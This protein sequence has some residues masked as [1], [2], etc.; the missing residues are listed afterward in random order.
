MTPQQFF[1]ILWVRRKLVLIVFLVT[2]VIGTI[3]TLLLPTQYTASVSVVVDVK[4]DPIA[5]S[6]L[7]AIASPSYMTTQTEII[8]SDRVAMRVIKL[9]RYEQSAQLVDM[10]RENTE[11]RVPFDYYFATLLEKSL[12]VKPSRGSNIIGISYTAQSPQSAAA[13]AN[14]FAQAYID[15]TID[16]RVDPARQYAAWFDE[17]LKNLRDNLEAAQL[18]LSKFQKEKG[19]VATDERL[20]QESARLTAMSVQLS[21]IQGQKVEIG[22]TLKNTGNELSPDVQQNPLIQGIKSELSKAETHLGE[23]SGVLGE[24]HPQRVQLEAQIAGLKQQL[25]DEIRRI[26]GGAA[27]ATR[28]TGQ[29]EEELQAL[30]EEQKKKVLDLRSEH[31]EISVLAKDV[32]TAQRAYEGVAQRMSQLNLESKSEQTNLSVLSPAVPPTEASQPKV[33]ASIMGSLGG[34]IALGIALAMALEF[35]DRRVRNADD[36]KA[37]EGIPLLGVLKPQAPNYTFK[38]RLQLGWKLIRQM[39]REL[40]G[41]RPRRFWRR[42]GMVGT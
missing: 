3:T 4:A 32:E 17:R 15:T 8:Q 21:Q 42:R 7:P 5:G 16:L 30:I 13:T 41:W 31:D 40:L 1:L 20:D 24:N 37:I 10:W 29:K 6:V 2:S 25:R 12:V 39:L 26:S 35:L 34:G 38:E 36:L 18:R 9:L 19:I 27:T 22:T 14:A 33:K 28:A 11:G 23:I